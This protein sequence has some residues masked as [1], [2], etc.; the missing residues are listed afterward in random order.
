MTSLRVLLAVVFFDTRKFLRKSLTGACTSHSRLDVSK[1]LN[2]FYERVIEIFWDEV[3]G[4][5][6]TVKKHT[7]EIIGSYLKKM[8]RCEDAVSSHSS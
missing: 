8:T 3:L 6:N 4:V 7:I 1:V 2:K 5:I